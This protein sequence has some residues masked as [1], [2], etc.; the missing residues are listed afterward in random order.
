MRGRTAALLL[1]LGAVTLLPG[2]VVSL[3]SS[4]TVSEDA[5]VRTEQ[6]ERR[7]DHVDD[8]MRQRSGTDS[9]P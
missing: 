5:D 7:M 9:Q 2:C 1:A 3:F 8:V 6:L 4:S